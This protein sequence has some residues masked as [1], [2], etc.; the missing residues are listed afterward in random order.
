[1][2]AL[3][4]VVTG[5]R[6]V[7]GVSDL[8][9]QSV[10]WPMA[11][12]VD[13]RRHVEERATVAHPRLRGWARAPLQCGGNPR[14]ACPARRLGLGPRGPAMRRGA[15]RAPSQQHAAARL[16]SSHT[17]SETPGRV[18]KPAWHTRCCG[19]VAYPRARASHCG[20]AYDHSR[21]SRE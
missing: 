4:G 6:S 13:S 9:R 1:M 5:P 14:S 16:R 2:F 15:P 10:G 12:T 11:F 7:P 3:Q 17:I 8:K 21:R 20:P 19:D 18:G